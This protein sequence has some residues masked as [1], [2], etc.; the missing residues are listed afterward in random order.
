MAN[1]MSEEIP[2]EQ[3]MEKY[4][5][6]VFS[7]IFKCLAQ[8]SGKLKKNPQMPKMVRKCQF[9]EKVSVENKGFGAFSI[10]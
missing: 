9:R 4:G 8:L 5:K 10:S 3:N 2:L 6:K 1:Q 7:I